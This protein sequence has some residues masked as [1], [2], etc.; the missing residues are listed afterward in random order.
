MF[1]PQN[2]GGNPDF[3]ATNIKRPWYSQHCTIKS[4]VAYLVYRSE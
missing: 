2:S 1:E 3:F 4:V